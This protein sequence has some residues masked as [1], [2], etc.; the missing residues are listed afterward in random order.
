MTELRFIESN[1]ATAAFKST[2]DWDLRQRTGQAELEG[3]NLANEFSRGAMGGRLRTI[4]A[5]ATSAETEA[6]VGQQTAPARVD[7]SFSAADTARAGADVAQGTVGSRI[8]QS[9]AA[10]RSATAG[11]DVAQASVPADIESR[12][13]TAASGSANAR[14]ATSNANVSERTEGTRVESAEAGLRQQ[15]ATAN[16]ANLAQFYKVVD[17]LQ[18]GNIDAAR[19]LAEMGG[20]K[21]PPGMFENAQMRSTL[22]LVA[23]RAKEM[24]PNRPADQEKFIKAF[25]QNI[26]QAKEQGAPTDQPQQVYDVPGA[27]Q[28][29]ESTGAHNFD[30]Y[31]RSETGPDGKPVVK[32]YSFDKRT[33][34][35]TPIEGEGGL[36][37]GTAAGGIGSGKTSVFQQKQGAY[38]AVHPGDAQG[39]LDYASG[40]KNLTEPEIAKASIALARQE[41][42]ADATMRY[43]S[44]K[45]AEHLRTRPAQIA[46]MIRS[47]FAPAATAPS[48]TPAPVRTAPTQP[49]QTQRPVETPIGPSSAVTPPKGVGTRE[50]PFEAVSQADIDWFVANG[51]PGQVLRANDQLYTK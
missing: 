13:A 16:T 36:T 14:T 18:A 43:D 9:G 10:A 34:T 22:A 6:G 37:R 7:Q 8:A 50:V 39:A 25:L 3:K 15:Q 24:Y 4:N 29:Q 47:G 30:I 5:G 45:L 42:N 44:K 48:A 33:G 11:A 23:A 40:K 19:Q 12:R 35:S 38:L 41:A 51:K 17:L 1:P 46:A 27:P 2:S 20:Q 32:S 26:Q 21:L 31:N 28:P 49:A